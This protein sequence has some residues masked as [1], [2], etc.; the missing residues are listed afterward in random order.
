MQPRS[1][2]LISRIWASVM[3]RA[4]HARQLAALVGGWLASGLS[5][6]HGTTAKGN[7]TAPTANASWPIADRR[8]QARAMDM[9][10]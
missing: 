6:A 4:A 5:L 9:T 2:F 10:A 7:S 1:R 8:D 3:I